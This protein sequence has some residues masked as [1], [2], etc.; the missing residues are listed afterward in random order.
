MVAQRHSHL[1]WIS[2]SALLRPEVCERWLTLQHLFEG[3]GSKK[4]LGHHDHSTKAAR[5]HATLL[6]GLTL[7]ARVF[8]E[9][10]V[11]C[12]VASRVPA[13]RLLQ[14]DFEILQ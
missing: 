2:R 5:A 8:V 14:E 3:C 1:R 6:E 12:P 13:S 11:E 7:A 9:A 10:G 4:T